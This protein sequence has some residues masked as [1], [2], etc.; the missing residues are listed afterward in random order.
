[1]H[2]PTTPQPTPNPL[3]QQ[4][5]KPHWW[6]I[7]AWVSILAP[8]LCAVFLIRHVTSATPPPEYP[9]KSATHAFG[10][11]L[12]DCRAMFDEVS[13]YDTHWR[14]LAR[15]SF[16]THEW[17]QEDEYRNIMRRHVHIMETRF[18]Y[19]YSQIFM[20]IDLGVREQWPRPNGDK[21]P[22]SGAIPPLNPR[23]E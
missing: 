8:L 22:L 21:S 4:H 10:V 13:G 20:C 17:S 5:T 15:R 9:P 3:P 18:P 16:P 2:A 11:P 1:M 7:T 23:T 6:R 19:H 12:S 14:A